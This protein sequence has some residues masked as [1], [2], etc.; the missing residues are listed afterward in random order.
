MLDGA[1]NTVD[2]SPRQQ[3]Q[4]LCLFQAQLAVTIA[5]VSLL[6]FLLSVQIVELVDDLIP[7]I[8]DFLD[9]LVIR[10]LELEIDP[11]G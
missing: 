4:T 9:L 5:A 11:K 7:R 2:K 10:L 1:R 6:L 8:E 3:E